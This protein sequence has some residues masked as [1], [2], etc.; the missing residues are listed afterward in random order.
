[1]SIVVV[2]FMGLGKLWWNNRLM[3]RQELLDEEKMSRTKEVRR[4][5]V[6]L[7][8]S[9]EIPFGV[10]AIQGGVE[11]AGIW[12]SRP[13]TTSSEVKP[14]MLSSATTLI[15]MNA[16][17]LR[18]KE[19][20]VDTECFETR[21]RFTDSKSLASNHSPF[22]S[23][24]LDQ[25]SGMD[26]ADEDTLGQLNGYG[27]SRPAY[28]TYVPTRNPRRP[29]QRSTASSS[30][31]SIDSQPRPSARSGSGRSYVSTGNTHIR[32]S[33]LQ[34][35]PRL[36]DF[37]TPSSQ[38]SVSPLA[39]DSRS[40]WLPGHELR[41]PEP[42]FDPGDIHLNRTARR[43]NQ[44]FEVL[45]V[46]TFGLSFDLQASDDVAMDG[47]KVPIRRSTKRPRSN[48]NSSQNF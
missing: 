24:P 28:D 35:H 33:R 1:M 26:R 5:G 13:N 2:F 29:S 15:G 30:G 27:N 46:G 17:D 31:E 21:Q 41:I 36:D 37:G 32:P 23:P 8:K 42:T 20:T 44:G 25:R 6:S 22:L 16:R 19:K 18:G 38:A 7:K 45:P 14:T 12:I 48:H 3:H 9:A 34:H 43:V 10:R 11:V 4:T 39:D 40:P 47:A